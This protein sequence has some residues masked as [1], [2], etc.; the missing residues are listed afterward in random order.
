MFRRRKHYSDAV[1]DARMARRA[2]HRSKLPE[3]RELGETRRAALRSDYEVR[4][5]EQRQRL[6]LP[7]TPE[8]IAAAVEA[9]EVKRRSREWWFGCPRCSRTIAIE[10]PAPRCKWCGINMVKVRRVVGS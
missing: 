7:P 8:E 1:A 2:A 6:K 3:L 9:E 10:Q 4:I 5:E